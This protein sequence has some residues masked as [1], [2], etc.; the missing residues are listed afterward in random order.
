ME[1]LNERVTGRNVEIVGNDGLIQETLL[2]LINFFI[3]PALDFDQERAAFLT[4]VFWGSFSM[5]RLL[6]I[7]L[8]RALSPAI[9]LLGDIFLTAV[10]AMGLIISGRKIPSILWVCSA[11]LGLGG[12]LFGIVEIMGLAVYGISR[13]GF[14]ILN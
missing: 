12:G 13:F 6:A 2:Q 11:T 5:G 3:Q 1:R 7:P 4:S 9:L 14:R 10:S 8:S